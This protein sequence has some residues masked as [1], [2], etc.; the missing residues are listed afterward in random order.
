MVLLDPASRR[1]AG[2]AIE[3]LPPHRARF[4]S[5]ASTGQL[6]LRPPRG[7]LTICA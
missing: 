5:F 2:P 1:A 4:L 7:R 6:I 3:P